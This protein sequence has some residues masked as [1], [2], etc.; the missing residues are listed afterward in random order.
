MNDHTVGGP[1]CKGCPPNL[2]GSKR[3]IT[4]ETTSKH[5]IRAIDEDNEQCGPCRAEGGEP[6][7]KAKNAYIQIRS[8]YGLEMLFR[9]DH[10]QEETQQQF[11]RIMAPQIDNTER[12]PHF[13]LF[14]EA[15]SGPG[16]VFLRVGGNYVIQ[17]YDNMFEIVGDPD[18]NPSDKLLSISKQYIIE[19]KK[20]HYHKAEMH[21]LAAEKQIILMG[22]SDRKDCSKDG[23]PGP[24]I[25]NVVINR[26]PEQCPLTGFMH[27]QPGKSTSESVFASGHSG[28]GD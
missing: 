8:G 25:Y 14:Q 1:G 26:C 16:L 11:I 9:D 24:C 10:S 12:G 13:E 23:K 18:K 22:E 21:I 20:L 6:V 7:N 28:C 5:I 4:M 2:A 27:F 17:T 19:T 15:P 3:G